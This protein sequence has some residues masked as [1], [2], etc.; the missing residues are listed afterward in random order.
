MKPVPDCIPEALQLTLDTARLV[1]D[2]SFIHRKVLKKVMSDLLKESEF[3][4]DPAEI[5]YRCLMSAYKALGVKD[6]YEN[7]KARRNKAMLGL[8]KGFREYLDIA[9]NRLYSCINL[10]MAGNVKN[11]NALGRAEMEKSILEQLDNAVERDDR[12]TFA[13]ALSRAESLMYVIDTAGEIVLDKLLIE[14]LSKKCKVV[15][16]VANK[17]I[18]DTA[19]SEDAESVG[20]GEFA[21]ITDP[22][23]P[24]MGLMLDRASSSFRE[25][26]DAVD[27]VIVKGE[28]NFQTLQTNERECFYVLQARDTAIAKKLGVTPGNSVFAHFP[29]KP[30]SG[31]FEKA[32]TKN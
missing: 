30:G 9:P 31:L 15:A 3:G 28:N 4:Q 18:L 27:I 20:L 25:M 26:F 14:E 32:E 24:M 1:S 7:E 11:I 12:E 21:E 16:V 6:P 8:E 5:H 23:A 29:G 17:P 13:K 22:G 19:T 10:V 2:D